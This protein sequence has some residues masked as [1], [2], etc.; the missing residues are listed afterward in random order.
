MPPF[1][2]AS[3]FLREHDANHVRSRKLQELQ[4]FLKF[5]IVANISELALSL[6]VTE[7]EAQEFVNIL[8]DQGIIEQVVLKHKFCNTK[9]FLKMKHG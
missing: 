3:N 1:D 9:L 6:R 5:S 4:D 2:N 8:L 7:R